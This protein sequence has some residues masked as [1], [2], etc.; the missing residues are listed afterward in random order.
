MYLLYTFALSLLFIALLPYFAYQALRHGK[1]RGSF[2]QRMGLLP[3]ELRSDSAPTIWI[4]TVSVGEFNAARP[5][6]SQLRNNFP[7][8]RIV[9]STITLTGQR[10]AASAAESFDKNFYFPFDWNFTVRRSLDHINPVIVVILE[11]ELWPNFLRECH[12]R[13]ITTVI[14]NGRISQ[15]SFKGYMRVRKFISRVLADVSL[16]VMQS[17]NDAERIISL[18]AQ[19]SKV[20][21]C[22]NLKYDL[23]DKDKEDSFNKLC[24]NLDEQFAFSSSHNLIVAGS[25]AQGEEKILL[26]VLRSIR[27]E[28]GLED[29]RLLVAPRHPERFEEVASLI[30]QSNFSF[31]RRSQ[32]SAASVNTDVILLDTIGELGAAYRFASVV[33]VGGS[34]VP[35]GGHNIIEPAACAKP[36]IVGP[37]MEN[38]RAITT[39]FTNA[40][41]L[42][43]IKSD[44]NQVESLAREFTR[45]LSDRKIAEQI[46]A[47]GREILIRNRG[48]TICTIEV[49]QKLMS[50]NRLNDR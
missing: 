38:F 15:K 9:V 25:T 32:S 41:A 47:R 39:D 6:I 2:K 50:E 43:Q 14:A 13:G 3:E 45:L 21:V 20:K 40:D 44:S 31:S 22:G 30:R 35:R 4:H 19:Q 24:Q 8:H 1:Y 37:H 28:N 36:V 33:F 48:A 18:G 11:T 26:E 29:T 42:I 16:L 34:L 46:G 5:L 17:E 23:A 10:L 7:D 27:N 49:I 12:R